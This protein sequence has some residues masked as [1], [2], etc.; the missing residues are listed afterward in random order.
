MREK[1]TL[2]RGREPSVGIT[3]SAATITL[4]ITASGATPEACL[5]MIDPTVGTIRECL[6]NLVF[7][8]ED[9]ELED[10]VV[11][12]LKDQGKTLCTVEYA[13]AGLITNV[14]SR[15]AEVVLRA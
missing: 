2:R 6:G 15:T 8:Q 3:V 5:A 10:A 9:D 14:G 12:L 4:R 7:G 1:V 11:R 13:T